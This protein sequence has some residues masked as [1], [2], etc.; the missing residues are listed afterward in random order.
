[1]EDQ[2]DEE[3]ESWLD[4]VEPTLPQPIPQEDL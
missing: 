3:Y 2:L 1:M 4:E